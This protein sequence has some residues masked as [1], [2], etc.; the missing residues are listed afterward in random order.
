MHRGTERFA[1]NV[2]TGGFD[3]GDGGAVDMAVIR[4]GSCPMARCSS[5]RMAASVVRM[6]PFS[7][8]SP[9]P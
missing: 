9:M 8:A 1:Q 6:K 4:R 5:S 3:G 2:P 7:V